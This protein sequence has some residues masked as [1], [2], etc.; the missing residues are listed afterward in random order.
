MCLRVGEVHKECFP[1]SLHI[2]SLVLDITLS[3]YIQILYCNC[4][5]KM[6]AIKKKMATLK[7]ERDQAIEKS[8]ESELRKKEA[9]AKVD[10]VCSNN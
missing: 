5:D 4:L 2:S 8:E 9:E 6:E 3:C 7:E 10:E 1:N